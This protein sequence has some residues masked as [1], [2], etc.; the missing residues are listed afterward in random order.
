MLY[1][2]LARANMPI[3]A[4]LIRGYAGNG[5]SFSTREVI[6]NTVFS[7]YNFLFLAIIDSSDW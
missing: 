7:T 6:N 5:K 4:V 1:K 2:D 3:N